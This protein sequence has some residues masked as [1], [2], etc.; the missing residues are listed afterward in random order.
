M[1]FEEKAREL[2]G[3]FRTVMERDRGVDKNNPDVMEVMN[4]QEA[5]ILLKVG[6]AGPVPMTDI[7]DSVNLSLSSV[8]GIVDKLEEKKFVR[9]GRAEDDRRVVRVEILEAGMSAY[10]MVQEGHLEITRSILRSLSA[11]EQDQLLE[12]FRKI[13]ANLKEDAAV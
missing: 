1:N 8:T 11:K 13:S 12:L 3:H 4:C 10:K 5:Q 7:A 9:R 2:V 6:D